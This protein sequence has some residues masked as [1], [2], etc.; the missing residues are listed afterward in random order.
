M[1]FAFVVSVVA[2]SL[3]AAPRR[4]WSGDDDPPPPPP[5]PPAVEFRTASIRWVEG[6]EA[7]RA[8]AAETGRLAFVFVRGTAPPCEASQRVETGALADPIAAKIAERAV[9]VRVDVPHAPSQAVRDF[10]TRY[11]VEACPAFLVLD[12][13]GHVACNSMKDTA[14]GFLAALDRAESAEHDF[15]EARAKKDP[16]SRAWFRELL[17]IRLAWDELIPLQKADVEASPTP[18]AYAELARLCQRA[19]RRGEER[20]TLAKAV[21]LFPKDPQRT[22]WRMRLATQECDLLATDEEQLAKTI[23]LLEPLARKLAAE[24]DPAGEAEA[25]IVVAHSLARQRK[26]DEAVAAYEHVI[27]LNPVGKTAPAALLG[28]AA[29]AWA[30]VDYAGCKALCERVRKDYPKSEE[31]KAAWQTIQQCNLRM[32]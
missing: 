16:E 4:A 1:R 20:D 12:A 27:E 25:R 15:A 9:P 21:E 11:G 5:P 26:F 6:W 30:K 10:L 13:A 8:K 3:L 31:A 24:K 7:G 19:C 14:E 28:E 29:V 18:A 2:A 23:E 22:R 32:K 17:G